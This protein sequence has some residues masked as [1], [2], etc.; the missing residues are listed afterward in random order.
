MAAIHKTA[1]MNVAVRYVSLYFSLDLS[2]QSSK[3]MLQEYDRI[4][5]LHD[6]LMHLLNSYIY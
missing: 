1:V 4:S 3:E 2:D 6:S 5:I